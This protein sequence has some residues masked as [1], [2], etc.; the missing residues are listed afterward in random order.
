[1]ITNEDRIHVHAENVCGVYYRLI[2]AIAVASVLVLV[3]LIMFLLLNMMSI[4]ARTLL[5][6]HL[7]LLV[8]RGLLP[9]ALQ[10]CFFAGTWHRRRNCDAYY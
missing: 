2:I 5:T 8:H 3:L 6:L 7:R 9:T 1:M 4:A 10:C